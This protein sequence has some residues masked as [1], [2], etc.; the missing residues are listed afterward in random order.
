M[1][2][3]IINNK[4]KHCELNQD[5]L[6]RTSL[7]HCKCINVRS[8]TTR[9]NLQTKINPTRPNEQ[10]TENLNLRVRMTN[11]NFYSDI[12]TAL[13]VMQ[14]RYSDENS[15]RLSVR[16]SHAWIVTKRKKDLSRFLY[17]TKDNLAQLTEKKNGWSGATPSI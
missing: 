11:L 8:D 14:T 16:L 4:I 3:C 10:Y 12:F 1:T 15:V 9:H 13:H 7:D 5:E 6:T 17:H 2:I